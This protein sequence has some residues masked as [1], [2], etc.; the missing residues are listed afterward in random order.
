ML[1]LRDRITHC[2]LLTAKDKKAAEK[3]G[4]HGVFKLCFGSDE[5]CI[6]QIHLVKLGDR[7]G[8]RIPHFQADGTSPNKLPIFR[9]RV[10]EEVTGAARDAYDTV[11]KQLGKV[12][13]GHKYRIANGKAQ[14]EPS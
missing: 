6:S 12:Q 2:I 1:L 8:W 3:L 13:Y 11:K 7:F 9:G 14:E 4:I 10:A 5:D